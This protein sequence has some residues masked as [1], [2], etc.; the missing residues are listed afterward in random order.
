MI[1]RSAYEGKIYIIDAGIKRI[2]SYFVH[3][4]G[5]WYFFYVYRHLEKENI[6]DLCFFE[7]NLQFC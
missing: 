1:D 5:S 4:V 2:T 6:T 7:Y 3:S